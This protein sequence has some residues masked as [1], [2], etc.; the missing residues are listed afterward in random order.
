MTGH[1]FPHEL[2]R[3]LGAV[4][5]LRGQFI[6]GVHRPDHAPTNSLRKS[7]LAEDWRRLAPHE[8]TGRLP[9][10]YAPTCGCTA[11][12]S[13]KPCKVHVPMWGDPAPATPRSNPRPTPDM[14]EAAPIT[15]DGA[16]V[17][18]QACGAAPV[19]TGPPWP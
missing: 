16:T 14:T 13:G 11:T 8:L 1:Q 12:T 17:L 3:D 15:G 9:K 5:D 18:I 2:L 19:F 4:E 10:P 7:G 6:R